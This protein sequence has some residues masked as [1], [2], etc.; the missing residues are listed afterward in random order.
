MPIKNFSEAMS[1]DLSKVSK[2]KFFTSKKAKEKWNILF[3][4]HLNLYG[5]PDTYQK[6][7]NKMIKAL[8]YYD[9]A[10]NG[11]KWEIVRA[12]VFEAEAQML[13]NTESEKIETTCAKLSKFM[14]FRVRPNKC[15][16]VEFYGYLDI[17]KEE[18][19]G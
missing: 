5:L 2:N 1:G 6:Y 3:N 10:Y 18:N 11:K 12:R 7:V 19:N 4:Q 14:G 8:E 13:I 15:T 16:V 9:K 17:V